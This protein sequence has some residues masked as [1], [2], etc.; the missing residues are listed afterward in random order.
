MSDTE[1]NTEKL[2]NQS[3][4]DLGN[5]EAQNEQQTWRF[6]LEGLTCASCAAAVTKAVKP[7]PGVEGIDVNPLT[8]KMVLQLDEDAALAPET[9][10]DAVR[11][12]GY[13][14][15]VSSAPALKA[16]SDTAVVGA[17]ASLNTE[18]Y[19]AKEDPS[20][21]EY[22]AA[23]SRFWPSFFF[24]IPMLY[25]TMG[26]MVGLPLPWFLTGSE[27]A[28][29][30][31]LTQLLLTLP[32]IYI[33]RVIFRRGFKS[34][35]NR[36]PNMD[37]LI[38]VGSGAALL[39]GIIVLYQM[40]SAQS[41][42]MV[43]HLLH[44]RHS[45][46]FESAVVILT[47]IALGKMLEGRAKSKTSSA[48]QQLMDLIPPE[49]EV[50]RDGQVLS[51]GL[52]EI[53]LGDT[54]V[55]RP[56][57][58]VPVDGIVI[59][60]YS[61]LDTAAVTGESI[62]QEK[63][64]GDKV[65][66]GMVN[67]SGTL[68]FTAEKVGS[69]TTLA[70]IIRLVEEAASSRAPISQLADR[71]SAIFVPVVIGLAILTL[72]INLLLGRGFDASLAF[73]ITVLVI[74]CPCALG[75]ATPVA[76]M[77][78]TG[79]G[80]KQGILL[81]SGEA[82]EHAGKVDTVVMD[83]TGTV[84]EGKPRV[85]DLVLALKANE[86]EK[87]KSDEI[88]ALAASLEYVSEHPLAT[89]VVKHAA[90]RELPLVDVRD[91]SAVA[92]RGVKGFVAG[93]QVLAG[94]Q[95]FLDEEEVR[96]SS[97]WQNPISELNAEGRT[98]LFIA[99]DGQLAM[100]IAVADEIKSGSEAALKALRKQHLKTVLLTGDVA[101]VAEPLAKRLGFD[102]VYA[103]VLPA[104]KAKVVSTL[105]AEPNKK[106]AASHVMML[107]DGINDAPALALAD[108]GVAMGGGTDIAMETADVVLLNN[109]LRAAV[110]AIGL[111]RAT[112]RN[113]KQNLFW[114]FIYNIL[115]IPLAAGVFAS[116]GLV[117]TPMYGAAAMSLSSLFVVSNALRLRNY[118][119]ELALTDETKGKLSRE[120]FAVHT[121]VIHRDEEAADQQKIGGKQME[122]RINVGGMS[123]QNCVKHVKKALEGL[124]AKAEV[125][126]ESGNVI[127][128]SD[129]PIM[130]TALR[131][132]LAE[133]GYELLS[134]E[135]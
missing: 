96:I 18:V 126:L 77:V 119:P 56:G 108:V 74:S 37:A 102:E 27:Y 42:G 75:L 34:L 44:L 57:Q 135:G 112:L 14:G 127:L 132:S 17:G 116:A 62:P 130:E 85:T 95:K 123:C 79:Q 73:A 35:I 23:K 16:Q 66:S 36:T 25:I 105:Q 125:D 128:Q 55:L 68:R 98:L 91:F 19:K 2:N 59:S 88:L 117:L 114:A 63:T 28:V 87:Q 46:Y 32:V 4:P 84:T 29:H 6:Q 83:K 80:A 100:I 72:I 101:A 40:A 103:G 107:G 33:N 20:H 11:K 92:G 99:V 104:D 52:D 118:K 120:G 45:L 48:I 43:E 71:I 51:L 39:Y 21:K 110:N 24:M 122:S 109:D 26:E 53:R 111:S 82:L 9:V 113:I 1:L 49:A 65:L 81:R 31:A 41:M 69:E 76:I 106:G 121:R 12:A 86:D 47:L 15:V 60:G 8:Q 54:I 30:F 115:G 7:L 70:Q 78:G 58:K 22:L 133:A 97:E 50:E 3:I 124:G 61:S 129:Q 10:L 67:Q 5:T 93:Q 13:D 131:E 94:N 64:V 89:A 38:A 90:E 134:Y